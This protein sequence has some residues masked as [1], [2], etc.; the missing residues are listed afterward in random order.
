VKRLSIVTG[1][2][3]GKKLINTGKQWLLESIK[4]IKNMRKQERKI[5]MV[6]FSL[7][8]IKSNI[9]KVTHF[10]SPE[11]LLLIIA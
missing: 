11:K 1:G 10:S 8:R 9:Q 3:G 7:R 5:K 4:S 6:Y 2:G